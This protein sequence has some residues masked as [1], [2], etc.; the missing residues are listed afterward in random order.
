ML[1]R[2]AGPSAFV[3]RQNRPPEFTSL[4]TWVGVYA[5]LA[6][7]ARSLRRE[8]TTEEVE[9]LPGLRRIART[10]PVHQ[11]CA[12][13]CRD[14][15]RAR[16]SPAAGCGGRLRV[17]QAGTAGRKV[18]RPWNAL[19]GS[20]SSCV[21]VDLSRFKSKIFITK[22]KQQFKN[23][24]SPASWTRRP[25]SIRNVTRSPWCDGGNRCC[26]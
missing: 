7:V 11:P 10:S 21:A 16:R 12:A 1:R 14:A 2:G 4:T 26:N 15:R 3:R 22:N 20:G 17:E 19:S 24:T 23:F 8:L 25:Q 6:R 5:D 9:P 18:G 13:V